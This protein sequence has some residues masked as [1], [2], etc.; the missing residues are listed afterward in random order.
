MTRYN[1]FMATIVLLIILSLTINISFIQSTAIAT[2][3][4][5]QESLRISLTPDELDSFI[6]ETMDSEH[7]PGLAACVVRD[8]QI[9]WTGT[10]GYS[11]I[12]QNI[13]AADSTVFL[14]ASISKIITGIALMQL[15]EEGLF[16]LDDNINDYLPF[17]V[18]N[19]FFPDSPITFYTLLTHTA[20]IKRNGA[21]LNSLVV[22]GDS[23]I[24]LAEF[25]EG[26]LTPG[27][28]YYNPSANFYNYAPGSGWSY[29]S[30]GTGLI[31]GL[32]Q[33]ISGSS[34]NQYCQEHIFSPLDM[35]ETSWFLAGLDTANVAMPYD[36][37]GST[38]EPYGHY[39]FPNYPAA[40][41][42]TS[43]LQ[44]GRLLIAFMQGGQIDGVRILD[45]STVDLMTTVH[46]PDVF[47]NANQGL[48]WFR[49]DFDG[50]SLWGHIGDMDGVRTLQYFCPAENTGVIILTN[51][52]SNA[53]FT[54]RDVL[55]DFALDYNTISIAT[56]T[57]TDTDED[58]IL[59]A[60]E[61]IELAVGLR[62][63][64]F[65]ATDISATLSTVDPDI[66]IENG[67]VSFGYIEPG[68][69]GY[70]DND[71]FAFTI[72][73]AIEPHE[74]TFDLT[75]EWEDGEYVI[76]FDIFIGFGNV[77]LINDDDNGQYESCYLDALGEGGVTAQRWRVNWSGSPGQDLLNSYPIVI[78]YSGDAAE[79]TLTEIDQVALAAYLENG[80]NLFLSGQNIGDEIGDSYFYTV[81]LHAQHIQDSFN[82]E[83]YL[84]GL[85]DDPIGDNLLVNIDGFNQDSP[86]VIIPLEEAHRVF[87]YGE[88]QTH[89]GAIRFE[90]ENYKVV[91]FSFGFEA[92]DRAGDGVNRAELM[93]R[94]LAY[95]D[96]TLAVEE[97]PAVVDIPDKFHFE[98]NYPNPFN[99]STVLTFN[100]P[101]ATQVS[102]K[103]YDV[104]GKLV[105]T[106]LDGN[107]EA[108]YH[109]ITWTGKND[110]GQAMSS[111]M[112]FYKLESKM[113]FR[114]VKSMILL[115]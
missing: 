78:W 72:A 18:V 56:M 48:I 22:M 25:L 108:G 12:E 41:L 75:I 111:G 9:I 106:L 114:E 44:L 52:E 112:Y 96:L 77:L 19:P 15:W 3:H 24:P 102:L 28:A 65:G 63:Y 8:G 64:L 21:V 11:N 20:S 98:Q 101:V 10:Y 16:E 45:S 34:L 107:K 1:S 80:G 91:Y 103:I 57:I 31:G 61:N 2:N 30:V 87:N 105:R 104:S 14:I 79:N 29:S 97:E 58:D 60:G 83:M 66:T 37:N 82:G 46:I 53:H 39:G 90:N 67:T 38:Y 6:N 71:S 89:G 70:N 73:E 81:Y 62:S 100:L 33:E 54:I 23:P 55:F 42:R 76:P 4:P 99:P 17:E 74:V 51:G 47:T 69:I 110:R 88:S 68:Q 92:V 109:S 40:L 5:N 32:V 26:Y 7:I 36:W 115:K 94:I 85:A 95:L 35:D 49:Q 50:R 59:E 43:T 27:G 113:G 13:E 93:D 84:N 86:G